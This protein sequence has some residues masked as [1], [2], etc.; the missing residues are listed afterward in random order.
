MGLSGSF[1]V[2][3]TVRYYLAMLIDRLAVWWLK[4]TDRLQPLMV[5]GAPMWTLVPRPA[6]HWPRWA[7]YILQGVLLTLLVMGALGYCYRYSL[8]GAA[9]GP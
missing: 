9:P 8:L 7:R 3:R 6:G 2:V 1:S 5:S 4:R